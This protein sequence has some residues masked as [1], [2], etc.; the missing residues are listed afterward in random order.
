MTEAK[1]LAD[2]GSWAKSRDAYAAALAVAPA[3][4]DARRW[5]EFQLITARLKA[6]E[7][8]HDRDLRE[9]W[10]QNRQKAFDGLL[11][12]YEKGGQAR[13][14]LWR[15][16]VLD[17]AEITD[18]WPPGDAGWQERAKVAEYI[19]AK[20][21]TPEAA[22]EFIAFLKG[23][24][25]WAVR[26]YSEKFV[27][28]W[29]LGSRIAPTA[30]D[31][32]WCGLQAADMQFTISSGQ[33]MCQ[34]PAGALSPDGRVRYWAQVLALAEKTKWAPLARAREF[35]WRARTGFSPGVPANAPADIENLIR[36]LQ[37]VSRDLQTA[38]AA[39]A[40]KETLTELAVLEREWTKP[41]LRM[42]MADTVPVNGPQE[43]SYGAT[44]FDSLAIEV[45]RYDPTAWAGRQIELQDQW[46][47]RDE[48]GFMVPTDPATRVR[49]WSIQLADAK[50]KAWNTD[51][52]R[53]EPALEP[54]FYTLVVRG[55][56]PTENG[57]V[58][59]EFTVTDLAGVLF[60]PASA[61]P[62]PE[63]FLFNPGDGK[64]VADA[65]V[66]G[67]SARKTATAAWSG[68]TDGE[69]RIVIPLP[70]AASDD[71]TPYSV[72]FAS[73]AGQ[74]VWVAGQ[75]NI[76]GE[77]DNRFVDLVLDRPIYRPGET[78]HW[79]T[80]VRTRSGGKFVV[81][82]GKIKV[83]A[84]VNR[85]DEVMI[86]DKEHLLDSFGTAD[87]EL[88]VPAN[89]RP[90]AADFS[91]QLLDA[92]GEEIG[93]ELMVRD[94]FQ[95]DSFVPAAIEAN[96]ELASGPDSLRPGRE[97]VLRAQVNNLSGG[98]VVGAP[99]ECHLQS[100][101][102][103]RE[104]E[105]ISPA[106][107]TILVAWRRSIAQEPLAAITDQSGRADFRFVLPNEM[108]AF[109]EL[110]ATVRVL[111]EGGQPIQLAERMAVTSAGLTIDPG[112]WTTW[113]AAKPAENL[114]FG[115][116]VK[117]GRG[118]PA[119]LSG[120][121][122]LVERR[123]LESWRTPDGRVVSGLEMQA[124]LRQGGWV[125][126]QAL[127][128]GWRNLHSGY[129]ETVI[130]HQLVQAGEDG[131][132]SVQFAPPHAGV[133]QLQLWSGDRRLPLGT[134]SSPEDSLSVVVADL[135]GNLEDLPPGEALLAG[136][137]TWHPGEPLAFLVVVPA[138]MNTGW[139]TLTSEGAPVVRRISLPEGRRTLWVEFD[140]AT[141][142]AGQGTARLLVVGEHFS[143]SRE[144]TFAVD[145]PSGR[146][147]VAVVPAADE[148]RAGGKSAVTL[149]V[150]GGR[151]GPAPAECSVTVF[152]EALT[153]LIGRPRPTSTSFEGFES[154]TTVQVQ[155]SGRPT[156]RA[157][158]LFRDP[159]P[160]G[161]LN[162]PV[163]VAA[164][165]SDAGPG[166]YDVGVYG[167][168]GYGPGYYGSPD[169]SDYDDDDVVVLSPFCVDASAVVLYAGERQR[170]PGNRDEVA[171]FDLANAPE[172]SAAV[173]IRRHFSSTAVW[174]P[175]VMTG[176][177]GCATIECPYPDNLTE[178]RI[179]AYAVGADGNSFGRAAAFTRTTLPFQA[180]L[181]LPRFLV[182]GDT[183][184]P[185]A[186]LVNRTGAGLSA[187]ADLQVTGAAAVVSSGS[188]RPA[189]PQITV[190]QQGEAHTAWKV[191]A[192]ATGE[193]VFT[194]AARA[195]AESD[196]MESAV[197]VR[198]DGL[199]QRIAASGRL[200]GDAKTATVRLQLPEP[201]DRDRTLATVRVDAGPATMI[202]D[203]LPYLVD[204]PYGCVEQT[205]SRFLPA[206]VVKRTLADFGL[207]PEAIERRALRHER[208][209]QTRQR[210]KAAGVGKLDEVVAR[211]LA[212]LTDARIGRH[213]GFG[214]WPGAKEPDLWMT[215][216]VAWGLAEAR[217]TGIELPEAL[218]EDLG[219][220]L[221][222]MISDAA[223]GDEVAWAL[224]AARDGEI[225]GIDE[226]VLKNA[227]ERTFEARENLSA[228]GRACLLLAAARGLGSD[229]QRAV[230]L[231]N[232]EN[233]AQRV[234]EP[235]WGDTVCWGKARDYWSS[236]EG[237][238][239]STALT[240]LAL[241]AAEPAHPLIE[242][243]VNWLALN[244]RSAAWENTRHT[245]FAVLALARYLQQTKALGSGGE[246][247]LRVN[248]RPAGRVRLSRET[249]L[250][251]ALNIKLD[252][253]LLRAGDNTIQIR[254]I[255]G[256]SPWWLVATASAWARGD[257]VK[258]AG[259]LLTV[260]RGLERLAAQPTLRGTLRITP[261]ALPDGGTAAAGEQVDACVT[262]TVP[263]EL[264][265][266]MV[267]VPRPAGCEPL[268]P[269]SG[270]DAQI[271]LV[272]D[273][274]PRPDGS[275]GTG[276][277]KT[278][279]R[280]V[281]REETDQSSIFFLDRVGAGTWVI[282]YGL[283]AI[284]TGNYRILP[285]QAS[286]M[287]V[288]EIS[289]NSAA[290]RVKIERAE[291]GNNRH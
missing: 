262:L 52:V 177:D 6:E 271:H 129:D 231:R 248:G 9:R 224:A 148:V 136:P 188:S 162:L 176:A 208:P 106:A 124:A 20:P 254:R 127:P 119:P 74:P 36:E 91:V 182:V 235:G 287:Y 275:Q 283:R 130:A 107:A 27:G 153:R 103:P 278:D 144:S 223:A 197:P 266:V 256:N 216:Y 66:Q 81:P 225:S 215:A 281:Y 70:P 123:W 260:A 41:V 205:M 237:R 98:P 104:V 259:H 230:L 276:Q 79:K 229:E 184:E 285:V 214:W 58:R 190:P 220:A 2:E 47:H 90:G 199:Q 132:V 264:E 24:S 111:P 250:G 125:P 12:P 100:E 206:V 62:T 213:G 204:Y 17:R 116:T 217:R 233:G 166:L 172:P 4:G 131:V 244:R 191:R 178:W 80:I 198:E 274:P 48:P 63:L 75:H 167:G 138:G 175:A 45:H 143:S 189:S 174:V 71:P 187:E 99:A 110:L 228:S 46:R 195:G 210:E 120:E 112:S 247:E 102:R 97:V 67:L 251:E 26:W 105:G 16:V 192:V 226:K 1:R 114:A 83:A 13:D 82:V 263:Q 222:P 221:E 211:S 209:E 39:I 60:M 139:L 151:N 243:A 179:E 109:S 101:I 51:R 241:L 180:R 284:T 219:D 160:G 15:T 44:G 10:R 69:G 85:T 28:W 68:R 14:E 8:P 269:L 145:D 258:P 291:P 234:R 194:L 173:H 94:A 23:I 154:E 207:D 89:C 117:N 42:R 95:V 134:D 54:G 93:S 149:R 242:P 32:A 268:N 168:G 249:L 272:D 76:S 126:G 240:V 290:T 19:L 246:V 245:A 239:E 30:D 86:D 286:A 43:F 261:V 108:P 236:M 267:E 33:P 57:V 146:L 255:S 53:V 157:P 202:L 11:A 201:L 289:A 288:P 73:V 56:G 133:F 122:R 161:L 158:G 118:L 135:A 87:G 232:L 170:G 141:R 38:G 49:Q 155:E 137:G 203:A 183:A 270:W 152:D 35:I 40:D 150:S 238:V 280:P 29:E 25:P 50:R 156:A 96:L 252:N 147:A 253:A 5:C 164:P 171:G 72:V 7:E 78:V 22:A 55:I 257:A 142:F 61:N 115:C 113:R 185:S 84:G 196:A 186:V 21:P 279:S 34:G 77:A 3:S 65:A 121:A 193:A 163:S 169:G 88:R 37:P 227:F 18:D 31:R 159:R 218:T 181:Q 273:A 140:P 265:Y 128:E 59:A 282:R 165:A 200:A 212:R 92:K 64:P 277:E